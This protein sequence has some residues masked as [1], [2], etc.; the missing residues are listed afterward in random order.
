MLCLFSCD[1]GYLD[2]C[3]CCQGWRRGWPFQQT[4]RTAKISC[5]TLLYIVPANVW[6]LERSKSQPKHGCVTRQD[7][8]EIWRRYDG[9]RWKSLTRDVRHCKT[10]ES[11]DAKPSGQS[12]D[13]RHERRERHERERRRPDRHHSF[14]AFGDRHRREFGRGLVLSKY[15][16]RAVGRSLQC[17]MTLYELSC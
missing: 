10:L 1:L 13:E 6:S 3:I 5:R 9:I 11:L 12:R 15:Q 16:A 14:D 7:M 2:V 4:G 8:T 17:C